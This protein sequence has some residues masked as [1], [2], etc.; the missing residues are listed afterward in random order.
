MAAAD[1]QL[2]W[3]SAKVRNDQFLLYV[4]DGTPHPSA[5]D[6][7]RTR[8]QD[9]DELRLRVR[10]DS[11]WRYPRWVR[12]E[13]EDRQ[14][15]EHGTAEWQQC[16][17]VLS[18]ADQLDATVMNWRMHV[19][20]SE[21]RCV[22]AIQ[23][24]HAFADGNRAAALAGVLLGRRTGPPPV[25]TPNR[26]FLPWR[27]LMAARTHRHFE[28]D[29]E[30]GR[31]PAPDGPRPLSGVNAAPSGAPAFRTL[32]LLRENLSGP[33]V[34]IGAMVAISEAL[35][36][37]LA[38]RGE[39]ISRLGAEVPMASA[40]ARAR[41]NFRN[42][43]VGLFPELDRQARAGR[44]AAELA[45]HRRRGAHPAMR[46][47]EAA[48]AAV[49]ASVLRWGVGKFDPTARTPAVTGNTVVSSVNRGP[50]DLA[51]GG[52]PV[53]LTAGYPALSPMQSLTHGVHGIGERL[54]I[55]VHADTGNVNVE[56]YV[57][58]LSDALGLQS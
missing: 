38:A 39:D 21:S 42:V 33:T 12:G 15:V 52:C 54:A 2:L 45:A 23:M 41:N 58:R 57:D 19:F 20:R 28:R 44:I 24:T 16:L 3:L 5:V 8:A 22:V 30:A 1:A 7:V 4:F 25:L 34:T 17:D 10:D 50:A 55:S 32:E 26:G 40:H 36:G 43:G 48:F 13:V 14:F 37:Y 53:V 56:E 47:S 6:E 18:R 31:I 51:F 9:C 27:G 11:R 29:V 35:G 49:P 46:A